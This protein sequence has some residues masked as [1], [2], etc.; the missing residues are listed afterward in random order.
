MATLICRGKE[1]NFTI[2]QWGDDDLEYLL[3]KNP[4]DYVLGYVTRERKFRYTESGK[5]TEVDDH[6]TLDILKEFPYIED[7][8]PWI[9]YTC[10]PEEAQLSFLKISSSGEALHIHNWDTWSI[11]GKESKVAVVTSYEEY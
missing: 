1:I 2:L 3:I 9:V 5:E 4:S 11:A 7:E 6:W 8:G 10:C